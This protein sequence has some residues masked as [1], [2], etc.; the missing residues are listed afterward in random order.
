MLYIN[1]EHLNARAAR[2]L[3]PFAVKEMLQ[4]TVPVNAALSIGKND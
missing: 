3:L 4:N 1:S 2:K